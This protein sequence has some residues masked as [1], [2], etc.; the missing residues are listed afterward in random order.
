VQPIAL[1]HEVPGAGA[2]AALCG[3]EVTADVV[4]YRGAPAF[5]T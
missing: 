4:V 1:V 2:R 3:L 5:S